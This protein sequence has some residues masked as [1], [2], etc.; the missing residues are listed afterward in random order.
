MCSSDLSRLEDLLRE[1]F[2]EVVA[3]AAS[4]LLS[5]DRDTAIQMA[6]VA[7]TMAAREVRSQGADIIGQT[8]ACAE[9]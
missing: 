7:T 1:K 6:C 9:E 5:D 4:Y 8:H 2:A 3:T